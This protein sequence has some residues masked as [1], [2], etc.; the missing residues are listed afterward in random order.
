MDGVDVV[1]TVAARKAMRASRNAL[2]SLDAT[3]EK[4]IS[5]KTEEGG[6]VV[7]ELST[8]RSYFTLWWTHQP[9]QIH[10]HSNVDALIQ[11]SKP[12][13]TDDSIELYFFYDSDSDSVNFQS[14][15]NTGMTHGFR[16]YF[17]DDFLWGPYHP[18]M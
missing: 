3:N 8:I 4:V 9:V 16:L 6:S 18:S 2:I 1:Y 15:D 5:L 12:L 13:M 17:K 14:C 11:E 10:G 7:T